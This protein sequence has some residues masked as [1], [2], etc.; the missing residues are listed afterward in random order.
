MSETTYVLGHS[1]AEMRRLENQGTMLRPITERLLRNA[2]IDAGMRVLDLGCGAGDVSMLAA[3]LVGP[4]GSIVGIDRLQS[5]GDGGG[6]GGVDFGMAGVD[7]AG[8]FGVAEGEGVVFDGID[9]VEPPGALDEEAG[10]GVLPVPGG[11]ILWS[12]GWRRH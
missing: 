7:D 5:P 1:P 6:E 2:G 10:S 4:E 11:R 8:V 3:E 12:G 9:A